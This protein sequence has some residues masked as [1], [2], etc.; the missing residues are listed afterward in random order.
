MMN[1]NISVVGIALGIDHSR[2]AVCPMFQFSPKAH[3][4][5]VAAILFKQ[6]Q[7]LAASRS[8]AFPTESVQIPTETAQI[9][10][11]SVQIHTE[12][13]LRKPL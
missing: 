3:R 11:E 6:N 10:T 13:A 9:A 12:T 2:A 5:C 7:Q 8:T 1:R 4:N